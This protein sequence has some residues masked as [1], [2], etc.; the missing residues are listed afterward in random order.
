MRTRSLKVL[1][2]NV[3][4][5]I[6]HSLIFQTFDFEFEVAVAFT[7]LTPTTTTVLVRKTIVI[8]QKV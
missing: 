1:V 7:S 4:I 6:K 5:G 8:V 2:H 3:G